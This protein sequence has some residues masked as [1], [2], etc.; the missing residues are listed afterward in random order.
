[1]QIV[2]LNAILLMSGHSFNSGRSASG[3]SR[4]SGN[5]TKQGFFSLASY[6][7]ILKIPRYRLAKTTFVILPIQLLV[8]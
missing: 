8:L 1:M 3:W 2:P 7:T 6:L 5:I 4:H